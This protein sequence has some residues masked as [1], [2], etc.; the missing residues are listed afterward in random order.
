MA[1]AIA[2]RTAL[3][4]L[5]C[6]APGATAFTQRVYPTLEDLIRSQ[7]NSVSRVIENLNRS[8][9]VVF[10][11]TFSNRV[12]ALVWYGKRQAYLLQPLTAENVTAAAADG[13]LI[14]MQNEDAAKEAAGD[15]VEPEAFKDVAKWLTFA[16]TFESHLSQLKGGSGAPLSYVIREEVEPAPVEVEAPVEP[17]EME[18]LTNQTP[19]S[20]AFWSGDNQRV[21]DLLLQLTSNHKASHSKVK[22]Q[23][24]KKDGRKAWNELR[25]EY[26]GDAH[27]NRQVETLQSELKTLKWDNKGRATLD[28]H[29]ARMR[30]IFTDLDA[31]A[32]RSTDENENCSYSERQKIDHLLQSV[33][34]E[35]LQETKNS[36]RLNRT[37]YSSFEKAASTLSQINSNHR[38]ESLRFKRQIAQVS[39]GTHNRKRR[40]DWLPADEYKKLSE[41]QK[42]ARREKYKSGMIAKKK[43]ELAA[44][45]SGKT[46][47]GSKNEEASDEEDVEVTMK[48]GDGDEKKEGSSRG[49]KSPHG[50][51]ARGKGPRK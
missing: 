11:M 14:L 42:S 10:H 39:R 9:D 45:I 23:A 32:V 26:E 47:D 36:I 27:Q 2:F 46:S 24:K 21:Y 50:R 22:K 34:V 20:G 7:V 49:S 41:E 17:D 15:P 5:G 37:Q 31:L 35:H 38:T 28:N 8:Q 25:E 51:G 1:E 16:S 12:K 44:L 6:T 29:V 40:T 13:W 3:A 48:Q 18:R 4:R 19:H 33:N 30:E 43:R